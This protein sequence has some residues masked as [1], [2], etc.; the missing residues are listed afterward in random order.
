M[1]VC[2]YARTYVRV[3]VC[4]SACVSVRMYACMYVYRMVSLQEH[5]E[6]RRFADTC[7]WWTADAER[8]VSRACCPVLRRVVLCCVVLSCVACPLTHLSALRLGPPLP[9]L[10]RDCTHVATSAPGLQVGH[11]MLRFDRSSPDACREAK[12][13]QPRVGGRKLRAFLTHDRLT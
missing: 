7:G 12:N 4:M 5:D 3:Y 8:A 1:H 13:A 2:P 10:H 11:G 6:S 9:H